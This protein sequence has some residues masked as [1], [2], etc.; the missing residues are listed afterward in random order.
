M[1]AVKSLLE[2]IDIPP[3]YRVRQEF[4]VNPLEDI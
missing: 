4:Y 2:N 1:D 3:M